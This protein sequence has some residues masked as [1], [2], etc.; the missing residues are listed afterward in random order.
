MD[1]HQQTLAAALQHLYTLPATDVR[2][3]SGFR[4]IVR[5]FTS[6]REALLLSI[7]SLSDSPQRPLHLLCLLLMEIPGPWPTVALLRTHARLLQPL[8]DTSPTGDV[9]LLME[10]TEKRV[11]ESY[12][13]MLQLLSQNDRP[14]ILSADG[15]QT[16]S[17][18]DLYEFVNDFALPIDC[19]DRKPVIAIALPNGPLLAAVCIAVSA[20]YTAAPID[21]TT[22]PDE[23]QAD[24]VQS[25]ARC[26]MTTEPDY[27]RLLLAESW[28]QNVGVK[29]IM[30]DWTDDK[31]RLRDGKGARIDTAGLPKPQPNQADDVAIVLSTNGPWGKD[32]LPLTTQAMLVEVASTIGTWSLGP[33]D[34]GVNMMALHQI[35]GLLKGLLAPIFS[36]GCTICCPAFDATAFWDIL[37][38][39]CPTWYHASPSMHL[40]ILAK[41]S[42]AKASR[43]S[44][45]RLV[46]DAGG[47]LPPAL[48]R[49]LRDTFHCEVRS[50]DSIAIHKED[51]RRIVEAPK[52]ALSTLPDNRP[53]RR[54]GTLS[55]AASQ[56]D[57]L[58]DD[59]YSYVTGRSKDGITRSNEVISPFEVERAIMTAAMS[60]ESPICGKLSQAL[61]FA[62]KDEMHGE[63]LG[64]VL[65]SAPDAQ[66]IDVWTLY[67]ALHNLS[68]SKRPALIV[69][70]DDMADKNHQSLRSQL[71]D[72]LGLPELTAQTPYLAKHWEARCPPAGTE[73]S[74][75][76]QCSKCELD[77]E[78][79]TTIM[80]SIIPSGY[81]ACLR[82]SP[83]DGSLEAFV[84][85]KAFG[86][87]GLTADW[88]PHIK[89]MMSL[90]LPGFMVPTMLH[91]LPEPFAED[92][93]GV[94]DEELLDV[95]AYPKPS[96]K[97]V[98]RTQKRVVKAFADI[99]LWDSGKI[100][101]D[102]NFFS[103]GGDRI[104]AEKLLAHLRADFNLHM[105]ATLVFNHGTVKAIAAYVDAASDQAPEPESPAIEVVPTKTY[106]STN[107][108]L[109]LLQLLPLCVFY[110]LRRAC[111]WTVFLTVLSRTRFWMTNAWLMGRL[112]NLVGSITV[113]YIVVQLF[114]PFF[115]IAMKW[116]IIGR[117][118]EGV[119]P[120]WGA[121][122]TRWWL[123][124]KIVTVAG[125]GYFNTNNF[126]KALYCRL[127]GAKIGK[128]VQLTGA[129]LGE[130]DLLDIR[131]GAILNNTVCRPFAVEANTSMYLGRIVIGENSC[132]ASIIAPGAT[133][134][135]GTCVG[136]NSSSW[137]LHDADESNRLLSASR[138]P[139]PHWALAAFATFPLFAV[140]W[141]LTL[142]PMFGGLMG[143]VI[144]K[145]LDSHL[146]LRDIL[147][148]FP[149]SPKVGYHY[150]SMILRT[151]VSPYVLVAF[152]A[153]VRVVLDRFIGPPRS[154]DSPARG[155]LQIWRSSLIKTLLPD[156]QLR[157]A[158]EMLGQHHGTT[159]VIW[160][161]LGAEV[162]ER[163]YWPCVA[164]VTG[165][166]GLVQIGND[167]QF[168][169]KAQIIT[170]DGV[171]SEKV[172]IGDGAI[173]A[174]HARLLPGVRIG[175]R[176]IMGPGSMT[177]RNKMYPSDGIYLGSQGGDSVCL[178]S[179]RSATDEKAARRRR[180]M[181][182]MPSC[183]TLVSAKALQHVGSFDTL[184]ESRASP[185]KLPVAEVDSLK[186]IDESQTAESPE[187]SPFRRAFYQ[188]EAPYHV[189][190]SALVFFYS[191]FIST[192]T[193]FFWNV[194]VFCSIK[195]VGR[196]F[197]D[198][199]LQRPS[200]YDVLALWV[201]SSLSMIAL[202][203][204]SAV[205]A[206]GIVIG[207]KWALLGRVTRGSQDWDRT[208]FCQRRQLFLTVER[209]VY[210]C[211]RGKGVPGML[212]GTHWL[213]MYYRALGATVGKDVALFANGKPN[214]MFTEPDLVTIGDRV[215]IDDATLVTHKDIRGKFDLAEVRIGD[216]CVLR[217]GSSILSGV[218]M[219]PGSCLLEHTLIMQ[220]E[221]VPA[222]ATM[223]GWPA[224]RFDGNR[225]DHNNV[226]VME[227]F[228][229]PKMADQSRNNSDATLI[230]GQEW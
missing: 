126:T 199:M 50:N 57:Y 17:H 43:Q 139:G 159:S 110:P 64:V 113:G 95:H 175:E 28:T 222:D 68:P 182:S 143:L 53:L 60:L 44:A 25:G 229:E 108:F 47:G 112:A 125:T 210:R 189:S 26:I 170:S 75:P 42:R 153:L 166:F 227:D 223:Q 109:M 86:M 196:I 6:D 105:P 48:A 31:I 115:G 193:V 103:M 73:V 142:T 135:Q 209:L 84:A 20:Y 185:D 138:A 129:S 150:L 128:N 22:G 177:Q 134:P 137:E 11:R 93:F 174:E 56:V 24:V 106:S 82:L 51:S 89:R 141:F 80:R 155:A 187:T 19:T 140:A 188:R 164:P 218:T 179:G 206:M 122:H 221:V 119:Y 149:S 58:G 8:T 151:L 198:H 13:S 184:V 176:T 100:D 3:S 133:I 121:Y 208:P 213:V 114:S 32:V 162:G 205:L 171:G 77:R 29:A 69:Y 161:M 157:E 72:R 156:G 192:F 71:A 79:I 98:S 15:K 102:M 70:M 217:S 16:I 212:S 4:G 120:M 96:V 65:V 23:F 219:E 194:P 9:A 181:K 41:A 39:R 220:D 207:A 35:C 197:N 46:C 172:Y 85:P 203:T 211:C 173:I 190:S 116:I 158:T 36:G 38:E 18:R 123:V 92:P 130:W 1:G 14:A 107:P 101:P 216:R 81:Q 52:L 87:Q 62:V 2:H 33:T 94:V 204:G 91:V 144:E 78:A 88:P 160:R 76:I 30:V 10:N 131:D 186:D 90:A 136:L 132:V 224:E 226:P 147:T 127:M 167:V 49:K 37:N 104:A 97:P 180:L 163:V 124:Q 214:L 63:T 7:P 146:P 230:A 201:L 200:N 168:D 55:V 191:A 169:S 145:P 34:I 215:A 228:E 59:G 111:Q 54:T 40:V 118:R 61:V 178:T 117:Y 21:P 12:T 83:D 66:R 183:D 27:G 74:T 225:T 152:T 99:L 148:W 195:V 165:D 45:I 67:G 154:G 202:T 5:G